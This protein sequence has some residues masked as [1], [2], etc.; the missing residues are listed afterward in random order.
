MLVIV[1]LQVQIVRLGRSKSLVMGPGEDTS[2]SCVVQA[3]MPPD[4]TRW[5]V[6]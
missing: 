5:F 4:S 2:K 6:T 1:F 3:D